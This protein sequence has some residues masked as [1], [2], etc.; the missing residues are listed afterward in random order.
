MLIG[1]QTEDGEDVATT[2]VIEMYRHL[3]Y[4]SYMPAFPD[5]VVVGGG[6][7]NGRIYACSDSTCYSF[8]PLAFEW[9]AEAE[10]TDQIEDPTVLPWQGRLIV[11]D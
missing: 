4:W 1:G 9:V 10:R 11:A 5:S 7:L 2:D 8:D 6:L 3:A